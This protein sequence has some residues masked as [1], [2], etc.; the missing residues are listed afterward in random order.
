[1]GET[2]PPQRDSGEAPSTNS[3]ASP[4]RL[5]LTDEERVGLAA[6]VDRLQLHSVIGK[7]VA[8]RPSRGDFSDLLQSRL[9]AEVGKIVDIQILGPDAC[10]RLSLRLARQRPRWFLCLRLLWAPLARTYDSGFTA[11]IC[12]EMRL[13]PSFPPGNEASP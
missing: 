12:W 4:I 6:E 5:S 13:A 10:T 3:P 7:V 11:S 8:S 1:M 2:E 9:L